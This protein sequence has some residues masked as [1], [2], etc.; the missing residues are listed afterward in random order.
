MIPSQE[1]PPP[2]P[3]N[4]GP[5]E[6]PNMRPTVWGRVE[7]PDTRDIR[8]IVDQE[9]RS[10]L[11]HTGKWID[12]FPTESPRPPSDQ[13]Q[14]ERKLTIQ[15]VSQWVSTTGGHQGRLEFFGIAPP[16]K[17]YDLVIEPLLLVRSTGSISVE[18]VAKPLKNNVWS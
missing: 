3:P 15:M 17:L 8:L 7:A 13:F 2:P 18:R 9:F 1:P 5:V 4:A 6:P 14:E 16:S 12:L 10:Y 11:G